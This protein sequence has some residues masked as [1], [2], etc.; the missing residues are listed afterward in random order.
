MNVQ[1]RPP[2]FSAKLV[3]GLAVIALGLILMADSLHWYDA[4]HLAAWWPLV[5][6]ALGLARLVEDGPLSLRGHIWLGLSVAALISQFG[7][8]GL[9]ERWWSAFLVW[10]GTVVTLRAIFPQPKRIRRGKPTPAS[11]TPAV[12]CDSE[13]DSTQVKP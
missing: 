11:P 9:L 8:W 7:P 13:A 6:T 12:S 4:W 1:E 2:V 3:F 10:G 5:L